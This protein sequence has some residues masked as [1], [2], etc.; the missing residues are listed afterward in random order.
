MIEERAGDERTEILASQVE[1]LGF[2]A[3]ATA[4]AFA[5]AMPL[6]PALAVKKAIVQYVWEELQR[7]ETASDLYAEVKPG[8]DLHE[9][10]H[11]RLAEIR[12]P[13]SWLEV[14]VIQFLYDRAGVVQ[15]RELAA[16]SDERVARLAA[17]ILEGERMHKMMGV[18]GG[19]ALRNMLLSEPDDTPRAQDYFDR[20]L[21]ESLRS[22]G[23][24]GSPRSK[25]A[26]ELG[27]RQRDSAEVIRDYL[28]E[29]V[30]V[31]RACGL[32]LPSRAQLG[33]DLPADIGLA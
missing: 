30:P 29:L 7:F 4:H 10:V 5:A 2:R 22:F 27:L 11:P 13:S 15:L 21:A 18:E 6:A 31:M 32:R 28:A 23:R 19:S 20:W 3:L 17:R 12:A 24:P 14:A 8:E 9:A 16:S 25:R 26:I 1:S 33:L